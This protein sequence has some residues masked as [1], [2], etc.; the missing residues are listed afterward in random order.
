MSGF[1]EQTQDNKKRITFSLGPNFTFPPHFHQKAEIFLLTKGEYNVSHNGK[2]YHIKAGDIIFFDS[3]DVHAYDDCNCIVNGVALII[4]PAT[5]K[6]FFDR[7]DGRKILNPHISD[8]ALCNRIYSLATDYILE[9]DCNTTINN[10][11]IEL[12]LSLL[13]EKFI[14][15]KSDLNDETAL[16]QN[17]LLFISKNFNGDLSLGL[18]AKQFGYSQEH[19]SRVFHRYMNIG[20][21][22][23]INNLR[24]DYMENA[25]KN[26][27][28]TELLFEAGFKSIQSYYR[29]KNKRKNKNAL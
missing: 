20:L 1:Y 28:V 21:P 25:D 14:Y 8:V 11:A 3:Y 5:A 2:P 22:E 10:S 18:L 16:M 19:V 7:K 17:I 12:I 15:G 13:E 27:N 26:K 9:S 23:Y 4:P 29:A 24:L 6:N